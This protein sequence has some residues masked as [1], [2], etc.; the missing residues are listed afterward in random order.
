MSKLVFIYSIPR[1]TA[2]KISDWVNDNSGVKL[3]KV[4]IGRCN[5]RFSAA[6]NP[7]VGG[8]A[9][10]ISYTPWMEPLTGKQKTDETGKGLTI[11]DQLEQKW[12]KPKGFF[13][14]APTVKNYKGDGSD[15]TY[16]QTLIVTLR[17]GSTVLDLDN[18]DDEMRYYVCLASSRVANSQREYQEHKW[19]KAQWYIAL[20][21]ESEEIKYQRSEYKSK[22]FAA[23][24]DKDMT[25]A[26]KR[27]FVSLL[28]ISSTRSALSQQQI[29]NL[30]VNHI[31]TSSYTVGNNIEKFNGLFNMLKT[32]HGRERLEMMYILQQ[33]IDNRVVYEKQGTYTFLR[34]VGGPLNI[35]DRYDEVID[36]LLNPKKNAELEDIREAIKQKS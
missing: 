2:T 21:N 27:K 28:G 9:N 10:Y 16:F 30:L 29:H 20:E 14:N 24:H 34:P 4:K 25:E 17:D 35:G 33:A 23:L 26:Y 36:F 8:L 11:Q 18:M 12:G 13:N 31:E 1:E 3:K 6:Y 32:P 5:D 7:K 15:L 19:P 22:A